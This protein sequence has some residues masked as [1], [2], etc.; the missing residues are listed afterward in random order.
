VRG[1]NRY[2]VADIGAGTVWILLPALGPEMGSLRGDI[3]SLVAMPGRTA[4]PRRMVISGSP[5]VW[6]GA[7]QLVVTFKVHLSW[8]Y[9]LETVGRD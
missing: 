5:R 4:P 7:G 3:S 2:E 6:V 1:T 8:P 9:L